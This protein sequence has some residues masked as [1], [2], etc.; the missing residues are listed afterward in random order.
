LQL[1][2][3]SKPKKK[4][5]MLRPIVGAAL[6]FHEDDDMDIASAEFTGTDA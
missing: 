1:P 3:E 6:K 5:T 2:R 4:R